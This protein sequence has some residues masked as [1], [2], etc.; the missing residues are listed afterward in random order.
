MLSAMPTAPAIGESGTSGRSDYL[1]IDNARFVSLIAIVMRH[2]ELSLFRDYHVSALENA[3]TQLRSFG[4][5]LFFIN[6]GFLMAAWLARPNTSVEAYWRGRLTR[7]GQPWLIWAGAYQV[8]V[9]AR[10]FFREGGQISALP[11]QIWKGV[12]LDNYWFVPILFFSLA[13]LLPL[14][15]YWQ[16]WWLGAAFFLLSWFYGLNQYAQWISPSHTTAFFGYLFYLWLGVQLFQNFTAVRAYVDRLPW[17]LVL[18]ILGFAITLMIVEDEI[19]I[20]SGFP[21]HYSALQ[22]SN[23]V[24]ALVVLV[25]LLKLRVRLVPSFI[26]VRR[27]SFGIYLTHQIVG[28]VGRAAIDLAVG[29]SSQGESFFTRLPEMVENPFARIGIWVLWFGVVYTTSLVL[30]KLLRRTSWA[31]TVGEKG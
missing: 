12:F 28:S 24:Y 29:W 9:L 1:F 8:I 21:N 25:I 3:I 2:C 11:Y 4:V 15:R 31:W 27:D 19:S 16:S 6:S 17:R 23:Q 20:L 14:R 7:V 22:N 30:T 5:L 10:F 18:M 26:D 13:I